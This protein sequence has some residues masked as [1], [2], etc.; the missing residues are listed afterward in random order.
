MARSLHALLFAA[1]LTALLPLTAVAQDDADAWAVEDPP[2]PYEAVNFTVT[3]GTWMNVDVS[4]DG[5]E[6]AFDLLGDIYVMPI[7]GG[8]AR[9]LTNGPAMNIQPRFSPDGT[10]ISFTSDR[11]GG[12]NIWTMDRDGGELQQVTDESFR[13]LNNATWTPDGDYLIARKHFTSRRSLGAGEMWM[14]HRAGGT[15]GVQLYERRTD[16]KDAGQPF[17]S[18]DGRYLYWSEDMTPG[19]TFEYD[20]DPN[21]QIY[22]VRQLDRETGEITNL[23]TGPGSA[24][25]P[26]PSPDG[27]Q[28]AFVR[29]VRNQSVL[30]LYDTETGAETPLYDNLSRDQQEAWAIFGPTTNYAWLPDGS[31]LITY[32]QGGLKRIDAETG[33]A[34]AIPF[35]AEVETH[36]AETVHFQQEVGPDAFEAKML[37]DVATAPDGSMV[38]FHAAGH[39]YRMAL[40]NGTPERLTSADHFEYSPAFSPDGRRIVYTTWDDDD[41]GSVRI[42]NANG[43][44]DRALTE[45]PG[46][47]HEPQ[48]SPDGETVVYRRASGNSLIGTLH[49]TDTGL[50]TVPAAGGEPSLVATDGRA[51]RFTPDGDRIYFLTGGGLSKQYKSIDRNG[52]HERTHF[53]LRD[54]AAVVPSPDGNWVA[55]QELFNVYIA[56]F[57]ATGR[58]MDL[59]K[60]MRTLPV[61]RVTEDAGAYLHW[62]GDSE[63]LHWSVGAEHY[64]LDIADAFDFIGAN[65]DETAPIEAATTVEMNLELASD[66]PTGQV[67]F[68]NAR[69]ITMNGDEVIDDGTLVVEGNRIV[70]VGPAAE[71]DVPGDAHVVDAEGHTLIP[72]LIDVHAHEGHFFGGMMPGRNWYY[73]ANLAFGITTI[74]DPS[75][76]TENVF[77]QAEMVR[78]GH[79]V[80]PRIFS[81]GR[82]LYGADGDFRAEVN[83]LDDARS[84][85]RRLN[86]VGAFSVK[87]YNQPRRDQRQQILEAARELEMMV[88]PEGGST[89]FHNMNMIQ[90]GHTG[91]EHNIPVAPLYDDMY[92]MWEHTTVGYTPTLVVSYGGYRGEHYFYHHSNVWENERLLRFVPRQLV[93]P[94]SRRRTIVPEEEYFHFETAKVTKELIDR[95]LTVQIG[96][97]GQMQG[98]A[99]HWELW[100]FEQ[101]GMTPH[102]ALRS[103]TLQGA[104]Y[105]GMDHALGSLEE[106]KLADVVM[107]RSNPLDDIRNSEDIAYVMKNGRLYDTETM[108]EIGN[109]PRERG[110]FFFE[111]PGVSDSEVWRGLEA[112]QCICGDTHAHG[113]P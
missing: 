30:F 4:P 44:N 94:R 91:I 68:T 111:R 104:Q 12:D 112:Q 84:H 69:L 77:N 58:T 78:A 95:G 26:T 16:Q 18:P 70:A 98:I 79:S 25:G 50:Y 51:P 7:E 20:K 31:G 64:T 100:M 61:A 2:T 97:H 67:A 85:L 60:D 102:E 106:G 35:E 3:E 76:N 48:F 81:T 36:V 34:T 107:L 32:A 105:L 59:T 99:S 63:Q 37:R 74:H 62:S 46:Y 22:T 92:R 96:G 52:A 29:R 23:I 83:S 53:D 6:I 19:Q 45:R 73:Y 89:F 90:D 5:E 56:P 24:M 38:V 15:A 1:L 10:R 55:F 65:A 54:V 101:G 49:S 39:L 33:E 82:I 28:I 11:S 8:T 113:R 9:A 40:P 75:A 27:E 42:M 103:A 86:A 80:G 93:D 110:D 57:P 87:S 43:A 66:R 14:Y 71:V 109:H 21:T 108:N 88:Y 13:L 17:S 47:Y 41:Y 72:G